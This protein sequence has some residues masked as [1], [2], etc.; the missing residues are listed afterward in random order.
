MGKQRWSSTGTKNPLIDKN[1]Y[2]VSEL[3]Q[4]PFYVRLRESNYHK[5]HILPKHQI[6]DNPRT[7]TK[8]P[9]WNLTCMHTQHKFQKQN[10]GENDQGEGQRI[11]PRQKT[12]YP[13]PLLSE[14]SFMWLLKA[15]TLIQGP[16]KLGTDDSPK[17]SWTK[18]YDTPSFLCWF[19]HDTWISLYPKYYSEKNYC[20]PAD[21]VTL[22]HMDDT[23]FFFLDLYASVPDRLGI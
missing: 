12:H 8:K 21:H 22:Y 9:P 6:S 23:L 7:E 14:K 2:F 11:P 4:Q 5:L 17:I 20:L 1:H 13:I 3:S 19:S 18:T 10:G 16:L 15:L